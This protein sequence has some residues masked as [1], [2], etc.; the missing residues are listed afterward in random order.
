MLL[1]EIPKPFDDEDFIYEI[2]FDGIRATVHVEPKKIRVYSRRGTDLTETFPE[3]KNIC[4]LVKRKTVFDGEIVAFK[5]GNPDFSTLQK[6]N[7]LKNKN[8]IKKL[9]DDIPIVFVAFDLLYEGADLTTKPLLERKSLLEQFDDTDFFVKTKFIR[10]NGKSFFEKAKLKQLEG[11]VAKRK[12]SLYYPNTRSDEWI[13]IKNFKVETFYI[14]GFTD[15]TAKSSLF[16]GEFRDKKFYYV[17]KVAV[18]RRN[19]LYEKV[20]NEKKLTETVFIDFKDEACTYIRPK[21]TCKISYIER[22]ENGHLRQP[23]LK[24]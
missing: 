15:N 20:R 7:L 22:T 13:K 4:K 9:R 3:L 23:V 17:G 2:K 12:D 18:E 14:G 8:R 24:K 11:I 21:L 6:R 1:K 10:K 16:L 19:S 5:D